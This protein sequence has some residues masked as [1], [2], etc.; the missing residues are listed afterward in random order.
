[1]IRLATCNASLQIFIYQTFCQMTF[2]LWGQPKRTAKFRTSYEI[3]TRVHVGTFSSSPLR[4]NWTGARGNSFNLGII[5]ITYQMQMG[6][7]AY[8]LFMS[9]H[10]KL[11]FVVFMKNSWKIQRNDCITEISGLS[12][13]FS[14]RISKFRIFWIVRRLKA[15]PRRT[16]VG[17]CLKGS[18][19]WTKS[20]ESSVHFLIHLRAMYFWSIFS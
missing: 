6:F 7:W 3:A 9:F 16:H 18:L 19:N 1:M 14:L 13:G 4:E 2:A 15:G 12:L 11:F 20:T 10:I 5:S 8:E 17:T